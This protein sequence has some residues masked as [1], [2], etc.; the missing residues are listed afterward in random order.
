MLMAI[1]NTQEKFLH[2]LGDIY[3]AERRFLKGQQEMLGKAQD[4]QLRQMLEQHS[5]ET[6]R[7]IA[8]LEQAFALLGE[9][10][11]AEACPAAQGLVTEAQQNMKEAKDDAIRDCLI[12]GAATKVEHYEI[13]SYRGLVMGAQQMGNQEL[14]TL[15]QQNLKEEEQTAQKLEAAAPLL[16]QTAMQSEGAMA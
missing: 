9:K 8:T 4:P 13:A 14:V 12:G 16:L 3:D 2:E 15:L 5:V 11:K 7:Q 10:P 1:A 6:E